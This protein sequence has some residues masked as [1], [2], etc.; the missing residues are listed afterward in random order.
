MSNFKLTVPIMHCF[1]DRYTAPAAVAFLSMLEHGTPDYFYA[2]YVVHSDIS[3]KHQRMLKEIVGRF[4]NASLEFII[5]R[6]RIDKLFD[7]VKGKYHYSPELLFKLTVPDEFPQY[8][9]LMIA[10][11]D[12]VYQDDVAKIFAQ[13]IDDE[14][15]IYGH[16]N[17]VAPLAWTKEFNARAYSA[18]YS[19]EER[20]IISDG[21]NACFI[22]FNL[23]AMR[24]NGLVSKFVDSLKK[25][26]W[27]LQQ[28]EQDVYNLVCAGRISYMPLRAVVCTYLYD[29]ATPEELEKWRD[30]M[31]HPVQIHY[32]TAGKPWLCPG[33][34]LAHLWWECLAR[35]PFFYEVAEKFSD[36]PTKSNYSFF[37]KIPFLEIWHKGTITK[38][39]LGGIF[40]LKRAFSFWK[41]K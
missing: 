40:N 33:T 22:V 15:Y 41:Q 32:A 34:R 38:V 37:G 13:S 4:S 36:F 29:V 7:K 10:D 31:A 30:A 25:N 23:S 5:P 20:K 18:D 11:V 2:L 27:R 21:V 19:E 16:N 12:V 24:R 6:N 28:P 17:T 3:E 8:N 26:A 9:R 39:R 14:N 1:D 35:T